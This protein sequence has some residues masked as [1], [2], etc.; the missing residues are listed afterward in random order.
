MK[1]HELFI[2]GENVN[3]E[4]LEK[5]EEETP[6]QYCFQKKELWEKGILHLLRIKPEFW[7]HDEK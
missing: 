1:T 3:R 5:L 2:V 6:A 4:E 7:R